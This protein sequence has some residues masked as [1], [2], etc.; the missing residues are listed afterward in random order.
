MRHVGAYEAKT[1]LPRLLDAVAKGETVVISRRGTPVARLVP[2]AERDAD[3]I[4]ATIERIKALR[5]RLPRV[6]LEALLA[7]RHEGHRY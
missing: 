7:A 1:H 2:Y 4:R 6:P 5:A 3:E